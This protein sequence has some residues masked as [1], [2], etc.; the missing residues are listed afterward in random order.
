MGFIHKKRPFI[1]GLSTAIHTR[2]T[3][4]NTPNLPGTTFNLNV[5]KSQSHN[6]LLWKN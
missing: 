6:A 4:E 3:V 5:D 2:R 1:N